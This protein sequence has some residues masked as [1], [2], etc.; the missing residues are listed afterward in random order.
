MT[1]RHIPCQ[2]LIKY[3]QQRFGL[4]DPFQYN[5]IQYR[6]GRTFQMRCDILHRVSMQKHRS[7]AIACCRAQSIICADRLYST[8]H[9]PEPPV[10]R[11]CVLH[12]RRRLIW[13]TA[14]VAA[15][16]ADPEDLAIRPPD[17]SFLSQHRRCCTR[18]FRRYRRN[19]DPVLLKTPVG[20]RRC[21]VA[22]GR[23]L[24][25]TD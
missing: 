25:V 6:I 17:G 18:I 1:T 16:P 14:A 19:C 4:R 2:V 23:G 8:P 20:H 10:R 12:R 21:F 3:L 15:V 9:V 11:T 5:M 13:T 7:S 22:G 24:F